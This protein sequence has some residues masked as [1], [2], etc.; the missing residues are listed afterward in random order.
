MP[1]E[2]KRKRELAKLDKRQAK[3]QKRA[4][5]KAERANVATPHDASTARPASARTETA[6][7]R[8]DAS[9]TPLTLADLAEQWK[10]T[11]IAKPKVRGQ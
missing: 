9:P 6:T 4:A 7:T 11:R 3:D 8:V 5:R 2:A 1:T 10:S